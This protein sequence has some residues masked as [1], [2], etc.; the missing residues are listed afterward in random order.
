MTIAKMSLKLGRLRSYKHIAIRSKEYQTVF[1]TCRELSN[2]TNSIKDV[3]IQ[4]KNII[5]LKMLNE[6]TEYFYHNSYTL[7]LYYK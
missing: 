4:V 3:R 7:F 2:L 1:H 6:L 5:W